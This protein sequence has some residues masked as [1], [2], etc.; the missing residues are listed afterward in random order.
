MSTKAVAGPLWDNAIVFSILKTYDVLR[1]SSTGL[2]MSL[3]QA[4]EPDVG[5]DF[6]AQTRANAP[7]Q[8]KKAKPRN[9]RPRR[10]RQ[11]QEAVKKENS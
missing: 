7:A 8:V 2:K 5:D 9:R 11:Y 10:I 4:L 1:T 6:Q 3:E